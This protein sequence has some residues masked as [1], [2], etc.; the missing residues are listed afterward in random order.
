MTDHAAGASLP[1]HL[2]R[3]ALG[4]GALVASVA[5]IPLVGPVSLVLAI[6]GA[7]ALR[8]CPACWVMALVQLVS[9]G[10]MQRS[11]SEGRCELV[12]S[13][14]RRTASGRR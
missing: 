8:G 5:L 4:F 3:G 6:V 14:G 11:C 10:R 2:A 1:R 12:P 13:D 7:I 9:M